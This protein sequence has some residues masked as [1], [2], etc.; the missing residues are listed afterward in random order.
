MKNSSTTSKSVPTT[1]I[2][3]THSP[4]DRWRVKRFNGEYDFDPD[5]NYERRKAHVGKQLKTQLKAGKIDQARYDNKM[6]NEKNVCQYHKEEM[7]YTDKLNKDIAIIIPTY[8]NHA[9]WMR[10]CLESCKKTGLFIHLAFD[11]HLWIK[12]DIHQAFPVPE[13]MAL[14]DSVGI[15]PKTRFVSVGVN[16]GWNM[17]YN[18]KLLNEF[19]FP[20]VLSIAGDCIMER[21]EGVPELFEMLGDADIICNKYHSNTSGQCGTLGV[22]AKTEVYLAYFEC[23]IRNQYVGHATTEHRLFDFIHQNGF[24]VVPV[25]NSVHDFKMPDPNATWTKLMG[26]RHLHAEQHIRQESRYYPIEE[27]YYDFGPGN[28]YIKD[29]S[30]LHM[31]YQTKDLKYLEQWWKPLV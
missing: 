19:G 11:N 28:S 8:W 24:K 20:Y 2:K 30:P 23:F 14:A 1:S 15:P 6:L 4:E 12:G 13:V 5:E 17:W 25:R 22:L 21:P 10:A 31:W 18:L 29:G 9:P 7:K 27:K 16:H 3:S 26:Y